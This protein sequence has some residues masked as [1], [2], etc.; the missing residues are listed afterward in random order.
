M[1][2]SPGRILAIDYGR[3]RI[4]VAV[5]DPLRIT[6]QGLPTIIYST[7][8]EAFDKIRQILTKYEISEL[9]VGFPLTLKGEMGIAAKKT[10]LF[11][12]HLKKEFGFPTTLWDERFSSVSAHHILN[13]LGKAPSRDK[14]KV[15]Q[16][17]AVLI[18]QGYLDYLH[19]KNK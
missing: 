8:S 14:Q 2:Q 12:E 19:R 9:V 4:G 3:K 6:A 5:S 10:K 15:D 11:F 17:S 7:R 16:I 13:Q 1:T 18:L